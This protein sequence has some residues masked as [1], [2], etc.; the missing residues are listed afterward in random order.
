MSL[1]IRTAHYN[2][3]DS[4]KELCQIANIIPF[5][6]DSEFF[7]QNSA[8]LAL[9]IR[10]C[11]QYEAL[12]TSTFYAPW[13]ATFTSGDYKHFNLPRCLVQPYFCYCPA[14]L[15][16]ENLT[17]F[18]DLKITTCPIH[19]LKIICN[20]PQCG[21][22][23]YWQNANLRQCK[24]GFLRNSAASEEVEFF[25]KEML[26][27][28]DRE[29]C[30][31][32]KHLSWMIDSCDTLWNERKLPSNRTSLGI[33]NE[34]HVY[35][36]RMAKEQLLRYPGFT[37]N[38]HLAPWMTLGSNWYAVIHQFIEKHF[39]M[40]ALCDPAECCSS[41]SLPINELRM[42]I[43][44][45]KQPNIIRAARKYF[46]RIPQSNQRIFYGSSSTPIC[47]LI[48]K[49]NSTTSYSTTKIT[50]WQE[51]FIAF[52][53]TCGLL[54]CGKGTLQKLIKKGLLKTEINDN[55]KC[56][57]GMILVDKPYAVDFQKK[58]ILL[59]EVSADLKAS[60]LVTLRLI[61]RLKIAPPISSS[62]PYF[63]AR[64]DIENAMERLKSEINNT[65]SSI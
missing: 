18:Q 38:M 30:L 62:A 55:N 59:G 21:I 10:E 5:Q 44:Q 46:T 37:L 14:C 31:H 56:T 64:G 6:N 36:T 29:S 41:I 53:K 58:Y 12:L 8:M 16:S 34:L 63:F 51:S 26:D 65:P 54:K 60:P 35:L 50:S 7:S 24:C 15:Q 11:P 45:Q 42:C 33:K 25:S 28:F 13:D 23:E 32:L 40:C 39:S 48:K 2:G 49:L 17:V 9:L 22:R 61:K 52:Q 3:Y 20:C 43:E 1:L 27:I 57:C 4:I 19:K 47:Q